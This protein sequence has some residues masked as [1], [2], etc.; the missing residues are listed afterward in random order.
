MIYFWITILLL[1]NLVGLAMVLLNLPGNWV[2]IGFTLLF[3][4]WQWDRGVFSVATL[5]LVVVLAFL[6]EIIEFFAGMGGAKRSGA[7][8][9]GALGAFA[10]GIAGGILGTFLVPVPVFGTLIGACA[11]AGIGTWIVEH[12]IL[13]KT[14]DESVQSGM[15]AGIG[16]FVGTLS[17]FA[18]GVVIYFIIAAA[19]FWK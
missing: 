12:A 7:S 6:G 18:I 16:V 8:W 13:G 2:M 15:G 11:G 9:K 14:M 3:A 4:W 17:K 19:A 1:L 10:G 5:V